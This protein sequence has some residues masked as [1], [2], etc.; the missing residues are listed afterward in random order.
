MVLSKNKLHITLEQAPYYSQREHGM[1]Q[2]T[3]EHWSPED[4]EAI[5]ALE[6]AC[7]APWLR[8]PQSCFETLAR[9]FPDTQL[10]ARAGKRIVATLTA[11]RIHW[12]GNPDSLQQMSWDQIAGGTVEDGDYSA[13]YDESGNTICLM[14]MNVSPEVQKSGLAQRLT[15]EMLAMAKS[16]RTVHHVIAPFRPSG[17]GRYVLEHGYVD[18][19]EYCRMTRNDGLPI[20]PWLRSLAGLRMI[21]IGIARNSMVITVP[22]KV[23]E[24]F[25]NT[26]NPGNWKPYGN[27]WECGETGHWEIQGENA[28]YREDNW[29][30]EIPIF[31]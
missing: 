8:T 3:I 15:R 7:W 5:A 30:G 17:R 14:S 31:Q 27:V 25:K 11:N 13:T 4:A 6:A 10:L 20:D 21:P 2:D 24:D 23:F 16:L 22:I 18:F 19:E 12:D 26:Y 9:N 28:T 1:P 29:W